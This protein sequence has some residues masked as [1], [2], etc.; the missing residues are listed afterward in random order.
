M[1]LNYLYYGVSNL[2]NKQ[3]QQQIVRLGAKSFLRN[4]LPFI[5]QMR[6]R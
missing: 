4:I 1:K 6:M 5:C 2:Y 3:G